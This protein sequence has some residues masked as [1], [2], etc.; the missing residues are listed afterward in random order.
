MSFIADAFHI[1]F[2][3]STL[4]QGASF[5]FCQFPVY[6][7]QTLADKCLSLMPWHFSMAAATAECHVCEFSSIH[8]S[9]TY[10]YKICKDMSDFVKS[11]YI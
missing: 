4:A 9:N 2:N 1:K 8:I 3:F 7:L 10:R 5:S 11:P 6:F